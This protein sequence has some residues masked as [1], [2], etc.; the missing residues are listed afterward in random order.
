MDGT[1]EK[2]DSLAQSLGYYAQLR[3][4]VTVEGIVQSDPTVFTCT[5]YTASVNVYALFLEMNMKK[6]D[7]V[8]HTEGLHV[9]D[10]LATAPSIWSLCTCKGK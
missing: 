6:M 4:L 5:V 9:Q 1:E 2:F 7:S 3:P 10:L 8:N